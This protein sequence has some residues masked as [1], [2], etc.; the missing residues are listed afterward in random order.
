MINDPELIGSILKDK[1]NQFDDRGLH[2]NKKMKALSSNLFFLPGEKWSKSRDKYLAIFTPES[3]KK[4]YP[5]LQEI[6]DD[7]GEI[8]SSKIKK[9][10]EIEL[11][12]LID[13]YFVKKWLNMIIW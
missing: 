8:I 3:L 4:M 6:N 12:D 13:R 9:S 5:L 7:L 11:K 2:L 1:F 10:N